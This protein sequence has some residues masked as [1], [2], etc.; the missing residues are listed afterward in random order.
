[1]DCKIVPKPHIEDGRITAGVLI[2]VIDFLSQ[3][4]LLDIAKAL[5]ERSGGDA[6]NRKPP[7]NLWE[8]NTGKD[9]QTK[10]GPERNFCEQ[11]NRQ[12]MEPQDFIEDTG[13]EVGLKPLHRYPPDYLKTRHGIKVN[14]DPNGSWQYDAQHFEP[15]T[16][17]A[18]MHEMAR[19]QRPMIHQVALVQRE[20]QRREEMKVIGSLRK[21]CT[22]S[23]LP[24]KGTKLRIPKED[25]TLQEMGMN[26]KQ[27][28]SDGEDSEDDEVDAR[29]RWKV[30]F[31]QIMQSMETFSFLMRPVADQFKHLEHIITGGENNW[32][33]TEMYECIYKLFHSCKFLLHNFDQNK[34]SAW[35][36]P[37]LTINKAV[38]NVKESLWRIISI[39]SKAKSRPI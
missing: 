39:L 27:E 30:L 11:V 36:Q 34:K 25:K 5:K 4:G 18:E 17:E 8:D 31:K 3:W 26:E 6:K 28:P 37:R 10:S 35:P 7:D 32:M 14:E 2:G 38:M 29:F 16:A 1:M 23:A 22:V 19:P 33:T 13:E 12:H 20:E 9:L 24:C 15:P 21:Q